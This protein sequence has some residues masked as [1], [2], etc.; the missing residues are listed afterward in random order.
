MPQ[1]VTFHFEGALADEHRMNFYESARFQYAAARLLVKLAQF[2]STGR[3]TQKITNNTNIAVQLISQSDGSFNINVEEPTQTSP[4]EDFIQISLSDL[5]AYVSERLVGK[6]D[7]TILSGSVVA[8]QLR[9]YADGTSQSDPIASLDQL[10]EAALA[11]EKMTAALPDQVQE[12][13]K[14]RIAETY[15]ERRL[16]ERRQA[17]ARIDFARSQKLIAMSAPLLSEMATALRRSA[18]TLEVTS[19]QDGNARPVLF[20][21]RRMAQEIETATVD[22]EIIPVLGDITQFNKDNGWGKLKIENSGK[23]LSFSIPY[24]LLPP[25]RQQLIESMK[26]D[27]VFLQTYHVRDRG[28][29]VI[30]LI[31]VGILPTPPN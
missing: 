17:V 7:E 10:V 1:K 8:Q 13:I 22:Q 16:G 28:G 29:A 18:D 4:S 11:D 25:M 30:R 23:T 21:D 14:R 27:S 3:F 31:A 2:R 5:L 24:D 12:L 20:L 19:S 9:R 6:I 15:R 26:K